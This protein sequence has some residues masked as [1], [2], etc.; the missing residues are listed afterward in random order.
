[1]LFETRKFFGGNNE[2][3][4]KKRNFMRKLFSVPKLFRIFA[5]QI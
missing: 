4:I 5:A 2:N 1:M 3:N